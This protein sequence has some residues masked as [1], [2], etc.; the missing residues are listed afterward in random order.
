MPKFLIHLN[1]YGSHLFL[2]LGPVSLETGGNIG[3]SAVSS[4]IDYGVKKQTGKSAIEHAI[5]YAEE[6]NPEKKKGPC[7]S[8]AEKT[9][10][11]ICV[12]VKRQLEQTKSKFFK[13]SEERSI[14]DLTSSLQPNINKIYKIQR[15]D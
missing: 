6:Q 12:I 11:E 8:F 5:A 2:S 1:S 13:K 4:S 3:L 14:K 7:L 15:L 9:N 10:S